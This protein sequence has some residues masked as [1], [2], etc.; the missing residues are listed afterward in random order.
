MDEKSVLSSDRATPVDYWISYV[1]QY[2]DVNFPATFSIMQ[3]ENYIRRIVERIPYTAPDT[4]EKMRVLL[5]KMER[6]IMEKQNII[7]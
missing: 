7:S 3:E 5:E 4:A 1:A 2:Y 6:Y